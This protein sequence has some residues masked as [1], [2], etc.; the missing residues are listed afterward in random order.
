ML[1]TP[2]LFKG[3]P[4]IYKSK[5]SKCYK[6]GNLDEEFLRVLCMTLKTSVSLKLFQNEKL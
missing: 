1:L 6:L 5:H 2:T 3:Q 4:Y